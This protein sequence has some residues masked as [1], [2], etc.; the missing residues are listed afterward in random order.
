MTVFCKNCWG[1]VV[2]LVIFLLCFGSFSYA[3][4]RQFKK[5][6][7]SFCSNGLRKFGSIQWIDGRMIGS[8]IILGSF[9][10]KAEQ[11]VVNKENNKYKNFLSSLSLSIY[12]WLCLCL[13]SSLG[14]VYFHEHAEILSVCL[15]HAYPNV[16]L[17]QKSL[18]P[19]DNLDS[20]SLSISILRSM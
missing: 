10:A 18:A 16:W 19:I 7:F 3:D 13:L 6:V 12:I 4:G 8:Y 17:F 15:S 2:Q 9:N 5:E 14:D 11:N 1:R 20:A